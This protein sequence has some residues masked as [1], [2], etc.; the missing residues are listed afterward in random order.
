MNTAN[1]WFGNVNKGVGCALAD[2]CIAA[3]MASI[4]TTMPVCITENLF[5][6]VEF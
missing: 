3:W 2:G 5:H 6:L 4:S 1:W